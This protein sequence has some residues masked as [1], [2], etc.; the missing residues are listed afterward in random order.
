MEPHWRLADADVRSLVWGFVE[1]QCLGAPVAAVHFPS[2]YPH[3]QITLHGCYEVELR[4]RFVPVPPAALWGGFSERRRARADGPVK[5]FV[6]TLTLEGAA[7]MLGGPPRLATDR[8]VDLEALPVCASAALSHRLIEAD[9]F[10]TRVRL[11]QGFFRLLS[12]AANRRHADMKIL[13]LAD[14]IVTDAWRGP[15]SEAARLA[16]LSERTLY[17]RF[18]H[19][20]SCSP[21][22]LLR[23]ARLQRLLRTLHPCP[24]GGPPPTDPVLEFVDQSHLH[25]DFVALT[26]ITPRAFA[27]AKMASGDRLFHGVSA[28]QL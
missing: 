6:A 5:S 13:K 10:D 2:A 18:Q 21:K 14:A 20:I 26:G 11:V 12:G 4:S 15:V 16:G 27:S 25:R 8:I 24:I 9:S 17:N 22:R 19:E 28:T 23:L 1:R 7:L 3:I